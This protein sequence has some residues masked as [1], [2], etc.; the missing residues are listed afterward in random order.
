MQ[1]QIEANLVTDFL[2]FSC[3]TTI[4]VG[5]YVYRLIYKVLDCEYNRVTI[6]QYTSFFR[7]HKDYVSDGLSRFFS[8]FEKMEM[9]YTKYMNDRSYYSMISNVCSSISDVVYDMMENYVDYEKST[10]M[11]NGFNSFCET[12]S[13]YFE[14]GKPTSYK[15]PYLNASVKVPSN[16]VSRCATRC[17]TGC[18]YVYSS[19]NTTDSITKCPIMSYTESPLP[20]NTEDSY[21]MTDNITVNVTNNYSEQYDDSD[22]CTGESE[23]TDNSSTKS[24]ESPMFN[25]INSGDYDDSYFPEVCCLDRF[26]KTDIKKSL[27][28]T[29]D[30]KDTNVF[31]LKNMKMDDLGDFFSKISNNLGETLKNKLNI[32][33]LLKEIQNNANQI[34][35]LNNNYKF[36]ESKIV[37]MIEKYEDPENPCSEDLTNMTQL[38]INS[39]ML[40]L[41]EETGLS[42]TDNKK[43]IEILKNIQAPN[44]KIAYLYKL[45]FYI[46]YGK[47]KYIEN[48]GKNVN[49]SENTNCTASTSPMTASRCPPPSISITKNPT[50]FFEVEDL[51][52]YD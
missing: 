21:G 10:L 3:L 13:S 29:S 24:I 26:E 40:R 23:S 37:E 22:Y 48:F 31:N 28:N 12:V 4:F 52:E 45:I 16:P 11:L 36:N 20:K 25:S 33:D 34:N 41:F 49:K 17:S 8:L 5:Y 50:D 27:E 14:N 47:E 44:N 32:S 51:T 19:G 46:T 42:L 9:D 1:F 38:K 6:N 43:N 15:C 2:F 35:Y 18:P 7:E 39:E 30:T